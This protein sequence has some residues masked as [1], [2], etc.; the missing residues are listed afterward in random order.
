MSKKLHA[1]RWPAMFYHPT[2]GNYVTCHTADQVPKGY[3]DHPRKVKGHDPYNT[4][5]PERADLYIAPHVVES[6]PEKAPG[7]S[8]SNAIGKPTAKEITALKE[9]ITALKA[10]VADLTLRLGSPTTESEIDEAE[11]DPEGAV[12]GNADDG[13]ATTEKTGDDPVEEVVA[14][15]PVTLESLELTRKEAKKLLK[16]AK[17]QFKG[18]ASNDALATLIQKHYD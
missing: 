17:V 16:E 13:S 5:S 14:D 12:E 8:H 6:T 10:E 15:G 9:E 3:V 11:S 2:S 4:V 18:N 1:Q 7:S